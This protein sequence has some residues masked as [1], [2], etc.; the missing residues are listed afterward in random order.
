MVQSAVSA[1]VKG[2]VHQQSFPGEGGPMLTIKARW[3]QLEGEGR[4]VRRINRYYD[5]LFRRCLE[6][7]SGPLLDRAGAAKA[8]G[9][10][11]GMDFTVTYYEEGLLSL[12]IELTEATEGRPRV[13]RLG[14]VWEL[15]RGTPVALSTLLGCGRRWRSRAM[16]QVEGQVAQ[17]VGS[18]EC[19][20]YEDWPQLCRQWFSPQRYYLTHE[21]PVVFY[22]TETIAPA[23]EGVPAFVL[24][25][26]A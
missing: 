4:A 16:E 8:Q 22:P 12:Y 18:G 11:V 25:G 14:D 26:G 24:A 2:S 9:W 23:L 17:R 15:A 13:V 21:G 10:Q 20:Y 6:R 19:I 5:R 1:P 3:P 7:W